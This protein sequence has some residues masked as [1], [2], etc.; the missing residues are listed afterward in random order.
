MSYCI[1]F[2]FQ[3]FTKYGVYTEAEIIAD[4]LRAIGDRTTAAEWIDG[5]AEGDDEGDDHYRPE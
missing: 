5:H 2:N 4:V 1:S 3:S